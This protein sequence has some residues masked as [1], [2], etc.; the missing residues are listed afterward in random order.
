MSVLNEISLS[1]REIVY[2]QEALLRDL[3]EEL[4]SS[5]FNVQDRNIK[6]LLGHMV[7][8]ASNNQQR[9]VRLQYAPRC[10]WSM[11][12]A[13]VGMLVFPDYTQDNDLWIFLQ[14]YRSYP[15]EELLQLW[16]CT[17]L[18]IAH[19]IE[20]IDQTK[21][22]NYW[23]DYQGNKCTL[24][25]MVS[26]YLDH[27]RL[28]VGQIR[29]LLEHMNT[30]R[31]DFRR[32]RLDDARRLYEL[33]KDPELGPRAGW[34]PHTGVKA[35]ADALRDFLMNDCTWAVVLK[36]TGQV[37]GA[38]GYHP[39]GQS[40]IPIGED[41]IEVGYWIGREYWNQGYCTEALNELL[42]YCRTVIKPN[43]IWGDHFIDNPA[44]GRVMEKCGFSDIGELCQSSKLY[45]SE[46][47]PLRIL[48]YIR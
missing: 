6:M 28:H 29:D 39:Y 30:T 20:A 21:L 42:R 27:L 40:V 9:M 31:L 3:P 10:G 11:P 36:D 47:R 16:K 48:R 44:S 46:G 22:D 8:S 2:E 1:I 34:A 18:H 25:N 33:A 19:L 38:I 35:S 13:N 32:W 45:K 26:G 7:D 17:N 15:M 37:I 14:D 4:V 23:I 5:R 12:D 41:D 24:R 43:A